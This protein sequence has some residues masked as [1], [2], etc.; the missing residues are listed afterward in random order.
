[1]TLVARLDPANA[2]G[3]QVI[4]DAVRAVDV[5]Q[6]AWAPATMEHWRERTVA[7]P[8]LTLVLLSLFAALAVLLAAVGIYGVLSSAVA[9]RTRELGIRLALGAQRASLLRSILAEAA[10]LTAFG[11]VS[12]G[13]GAL[14][15]GRYL[16]TVFFD[17]RLADPLVLAGIPV[18]VLAVA[19][20]ASY[21]PARRAMRVD[22]AQALRA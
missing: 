5:Q 19:L 6:P 21:L 4:A 2:R 17:L 16:R 22:P 14:A 8:R 18:L 10:A 1:M 13:A 7:Q 12:G 11:T 20:L 15:A 9:R 3:P